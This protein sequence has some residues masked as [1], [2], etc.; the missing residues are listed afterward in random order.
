MKGGRAR[1]VT[2]INFQYPHQQSYQRNQVLARTT[3]S[4]TIEMV[5]QVSGIGKFQHNTMV[6]LQ[7]C[8]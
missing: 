2:Y 3:A 5:T 7:Y 4:V 6:N 1:I 8:S